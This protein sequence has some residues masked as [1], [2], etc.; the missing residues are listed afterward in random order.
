MLASFLVN[1]QFLQSVAFALHNHLRHVI[2]VQSRKQLIISRGKND[3]NFLI[4]ARMKNVLAFSTCFRK[5]DWA[6]AQLY[7]VLVAGLLQILQ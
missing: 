7:P 4:W 2:T 6:I 1:K 5:F 3:C